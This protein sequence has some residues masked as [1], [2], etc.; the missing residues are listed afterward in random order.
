MKTLKRTFEGWYWALMTA[1]ISLIL[2]S[3]TRTF[4]EAFFLAVMLLPGV[5]F[6]KYFSGDI[7]FRNR[8]LG[9]LHSVYFVIIVLLIEY[10][11]ILMVYWLTFNDRSVPQGVLLN[12]LFLA[13]LPVALLS[14]ERLLK[15]R[16]FTS[17]E[18]GE[19]YITFTSDRQ[20]IS[21]ELDTVLYIESRDEQVLVVTVS[22]EVW[23]T[24]MKISQWEA[25]LDRRFIRVHRAFIVNRRHITRF[26]ARAV[27]LGEQVVEISRKYKESVAEKL[28]K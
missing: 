2:T 12:P 20:K 21:L 15:I 11:S 14:I 6:V 8:R 10:L 25:V 19:R 24:R 7:S 26:D 27:Y 18:S 9:I 28:E 23:P 17:D 22:G 5:L 3:V 1:T 16:F 13:L 4:G